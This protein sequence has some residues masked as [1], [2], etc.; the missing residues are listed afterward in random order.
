MPDTFLI[1]DGHA[2]I[3]RAYHAFPKTLTSSSGQL[4]NAVYGFAR[5]LL[6]S[7]QDFDPKYLVVAFDHKEKTFRHEKFV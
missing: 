7:I 6:K 4:T 1:I 2:L 3:Y 5:I